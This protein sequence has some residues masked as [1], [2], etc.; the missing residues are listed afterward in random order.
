MKYIAEQGLYNRSSRFDTSP[1]TMRIDAYSPSD[2]L[3]LPYAVYSPVIF[4]EHYFSFI[5]DLNCTMNECSTPNQDIIPSNSTD[6]LKYE[7][8]PKNSND[9]PFRSSD[10]IV[11]DRLTGKGRPP[12]QNEYLF[13]IL[14]NPRYSNYVEWIDQKNGLFKIQEPG[15]VAALWQRVKN[16]RTQGIMDYDTFARGIRYYYKTGAMTKTHKKYTFKF[17]QKQ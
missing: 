1:Q 7:A 15:C 5:S 13:L 3:M 9:I 6:Y 17:N 10:W 8:K 16:R 2:S 4:H 11:Y 12:R 14:N